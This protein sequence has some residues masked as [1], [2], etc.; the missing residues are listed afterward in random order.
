MCHPT[1]RISH[2]KAY[3]TPAIEHCLEWEI[4]QWV[5]HEQSIPWPITPLY[6]KLIVYHGTT[7][8]SHFSRMLSIF[9]IFIRIL[10]ATF[11]LVDMGFKGM[12]SDPHHRYRGPPVGCGF[13]G[14]MLWAHSATLHC[15]TLVTGTQDRQHTLL[16]DRKAHTTVL[17]L[18]VR[19]T[20][21][22]SCVSNQLKQIGHL[23]Q[24]VLTLVTDNISIYLATF[25]TD[26]WGG[27]VKKSNR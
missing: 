10:A 7:S 26:R 9:Q 27:W 2:T 5:H 21:S 1:D 4:D 19:K 22:N 13:H 20:L 12:L 14:T 11:W 15:L 8:R 25:M 23:Y 17:D 24:D 6:H 18:R 16:T 3:V